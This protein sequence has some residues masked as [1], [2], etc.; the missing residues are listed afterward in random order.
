MFALFATA[1]ESVA[2]A[3]TMVPLLPEVTLASTALVASP[4]EWSHFATNGPGVWES[5]F[6][7]GVPTLCRP[8]PP[9]R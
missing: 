3:R 2:L 7:T 5:V 6:P 4:P 9:R 8:G 1:I